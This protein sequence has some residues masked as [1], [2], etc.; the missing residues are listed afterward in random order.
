MHGKT[1]SPTLCAT[2]PNLYVMRRTV[3][4]SDVDLSNGRKAGGQPSSSAS[5]SIRQE[6]TTEASR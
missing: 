3:S 1:S 6:S 2:T 5:L 4:P